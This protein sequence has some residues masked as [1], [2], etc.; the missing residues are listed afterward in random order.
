MP[1]E[2]FFEL[3]GD[4]DGESLPSMFDLAAKPGEPK[5]A[6]AEEIAPR[7]DSPAR[8]ALSR[9]F[10]HRLD[11]LKNG[12]ATDA[13]L[14]IFHLIYPEARTLLDYLDSPVV[15]LDQ[16]ERL[17]ERSDNRTLEFQEQFKTALGRDEAMPAQA[18]LLLS[19]DQVLPALDAH[20]VLTLTPLPA[21]RRISR[22]RR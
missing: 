10:A 4:G 19:Y 13:M 21:Q 8:T 7:R 14:S 5:S 9:N 18:D 15:F 2:Q 22:P 16:P 20:P 11:A 6:K 12:H 17:R 3:M 1:F